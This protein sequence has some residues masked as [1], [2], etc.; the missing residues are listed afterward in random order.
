MKIRKLTWNCKGFDYNEPN[1]DIIINDKITL[2]K[3]K[4]EGFML[5]LSGLGLYKYER[6]LLN[7]KRFSFEKHATLYFLKWYISYDKRNYKKQYKNVNI[8]SDIILF[9]TSEFF[10]KIKNKVVDIYNNILYKIK[11]RKQYE[12]GMDRYWEGDYKFTSDMLSAFQLA[13]NYE[14]DLYLNGKLILSPLGL[15]YEDNVRLIQKYLGKR[16][17]NN[18]S[19]NL[20]GYKNPYDKEIKNFQEVVRN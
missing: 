19:F 9:D 2:S 11:F 17:A 15:E 5:T 4:W 10:N 6:E 18:K 7:I 3:G 16:Y 14:A 12:F 20:K 8:T 1:T 13:S